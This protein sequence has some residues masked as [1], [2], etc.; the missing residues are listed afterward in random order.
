M[1]TSFR[2]FLRLYLRNVPCDLVFYA[3]YCRTLQLTQV[4]RVASRHSDLPLPA[5]TT[6]GLRTDTMPDPRVFIIRHGETEWSLNG[7][8]TGVSDIPL[9]EN[10]EKRV[11]ATGKALVGDDRLIVPSNLAHMYVQPPFSNPPDT[12]QETPKLSQTLTPRTQ[13]RLPPHALPT[14]PRTPQ[15]RLQRTLP[16]ARRLKTA[17]AGHPHTRHNRSHRSRPRMGLR[18]LRRPRDL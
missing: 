5:A 15:P 3:I 14:H 1:H 12:T 10:G 4:T 11:K 8:H 9:T 16:L 18:R 7:R 17:H 2:A 13:L 6:A